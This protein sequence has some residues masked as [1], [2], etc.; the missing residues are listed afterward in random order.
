[1]AYLAGFEHV[2]RIRAIVAT[3]AVPP[4]RTQIPDADPINRLAFYLPKAEKSPAAAAQKA[5][6]EK[7]R[8][9]KFP[10]TEKAIGDQ[11][12]ELTADELAELARWIDTLDR[13]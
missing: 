6:V 11:P 12:R 7:L 3:G 9:A 10:V 8:A 13:I 1:M 2:D 5:L 4:A